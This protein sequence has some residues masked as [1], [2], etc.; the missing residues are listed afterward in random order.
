MD[1]PHDPVVT[2]AVGAEFPSRQNLKIA[3]LAAAIKGMYEFD[4]MRSEGNRYIIQC[5]VPECRFKLHSTSVGGSSTFR[6]KTSV[7]VHDCFG[8]NHRGHA[9]ATVTFLAQYLQDKVS[10]KPKYPPID[11]VSDIRC[12]LGVEISYSKAYCAKEWALQNINGSHQDAYAR[13]P[14]YCEDILKT[15]PGSTAIFEMNADSQKFTRTFVSFGASALGLAYCKPIIGVNGTHLKHKYCGIL[16][17]AT[18]IDSNGCLFPVAHA[19]VDQE[20]DE[21]WL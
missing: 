3:C 18:S 8:L 20:N 5:K 10:E 14:Q 9:Q 16:L 19:I 12:K 6:I 21:N 1:Q 13:L 7:S 4:T 15:N 2:F 11:I 17:A